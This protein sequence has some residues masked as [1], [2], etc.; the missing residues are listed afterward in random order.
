MTTKQHLMPHGHNPFCVDTRTCRL[1]R[2]AVGTAVH[3]A[4]ST[5]VHNLL[6]WPHGSGSND[7]IETLRPGNTAGG[8][9]IEHFPRRL[10]SL[11]TDPTENQRKP[12]NTRHAFTPGFYPA[13]VRR[14][15]H[16]CNSH[17]F[18]N[19]SRLGGCSSRMQVQTRLLLCFTY[20]TE[21]YKIWMSAV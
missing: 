10:A 11:C 4:P 21:V 19:P 7:Q 3:R 14:T 15:G 9:R 8:T 2:C 5:A 12:T 6:P 13:L 20:T 1:A 18:C 17:A 16:R